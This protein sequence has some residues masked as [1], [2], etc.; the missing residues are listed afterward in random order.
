MTINTHIT[1]SSVTHLFLLEHPLKSIWSLGWRA[2]S[3]WNWSNFTWVQYF[4]PGSK[5]QIIKDKCNCWSQM[6]KM[7]DSLLQQYII[8][9]WVLCKLIHTKSS[10]AAS[11]IVFKQAEKIKWRMKMNEEWRMMKDEE[12]M[13][14]DYDFKL[15]RGFIT[16]RWTDICECRVT[17]ATENIS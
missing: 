15:L 6:V 14:K 10:V 5:M 11:K 12:W 3:E 16:D 7:V 9:I 13:I 8:Q 4:Q 1:T 2:R 17:F